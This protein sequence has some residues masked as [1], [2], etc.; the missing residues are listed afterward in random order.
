MPFEKG[1]KK[2]GGRV[3]GKPNTVTLLRTDIAQQFLECVNE[4][5]GVRQVFM[6]TWNNRKTKHMI[7]D[8]LFKQFIPKKVDVEVTAPIEVVIVDH[9]GTGE[10]KD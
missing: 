7:A 2:T 3:K 9:V 4:V 10:K 8:T 5:G 1:K 6:E